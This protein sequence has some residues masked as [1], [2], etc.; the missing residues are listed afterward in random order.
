MSAGLIGVTGV[1]VTLVLMAFR[2]PIA[3]ALGAVSIAGIMSLVSF[4]AG[5]GIISGVPF[6]FIGNWSLITQLVRPFRTGSN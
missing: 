5:M 6:N 3:V 4:K 2:V 1:V